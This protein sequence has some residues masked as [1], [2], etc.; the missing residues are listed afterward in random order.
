[1]STI[2]RIDGAKKTYKGVFQQPRTAV[3]GVSINVEEGTVH[4]LLGHNGAGKTTTIKML[5][6]LVR[7][8]AGEF[9]VAGMDPRTARGRR[10]IGYLPEQPYYP[11]HLKAR[12]GLLY[13]GRLAAGREM[14]AERV[15]E[16]LEFV[17]LAPHA[18]IPLSKF[19]RGMLQRFGFAQALAADP[20]V[21]VLDEPA[22]G[23]DPVGQRDV[24][25]AILSLKEEGKTVLLSSHQLSEIEAVCDRV[26][27]LLRG[28]VAA[29]GRLDDLLN[30]EGQTSVTA[31]GLP[32][33]L[34]EEVARLVTDHAV[35]GG[36]HVFSARDEDVRAVVDAIDDAGGTL[37]SVSPKR[38]SLEDYFDRLLRGEGG[39]G[40]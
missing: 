8:D 4:G 10:A 34:P 20:S 13:Y 14:T 1:M 12:K 26:T 9:E 25:N 33:E 11:T 36:M 29:E 16:L 2:L 6:G 37:V 21:V 28:K 35:S 15:E 19:S 30:V 40:A 23:L 39:D 27:I 18:E 24:R 32:S 3:D 38:Q 17:G 22:S 7:A 31:R 5:L